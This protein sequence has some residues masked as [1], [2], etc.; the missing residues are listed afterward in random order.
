MKAKG[1]LILAIITILLV[2][3]PLTAAEDAVIAG[4]APEKEWDKTFGGSSGD[5][6]RSVAQTSDGGYIIT[7]TTFSYGAGSSDIWL[8]KT[9]AS[10]NEEWN[11]TFGGESRDDGYCVVQ[12]TDGGYVIAGTSQSYGAGYGDIWI[13]KTDASGNEDWIQLVG[14]TSVDMGYSVIQTAEGGYTAVGTWTAGTPGY[15]I[16]LV[17]ID[18]EGSFLGTVSIGGSDDDYG[19]SIAQRTDGG[20]I[21]VGYT[22]SYGEGSTDVWLVK[23]DAYGNIVWDKTFGG[24]GAEYGNDV[25]QTSD[26]GY[27]IA[28]YTNSFDVWLIKTDASG[29]EEWDKTFGG[30]NSDEGKS[31]AQT[32]DGG[33][34]ITGYTYSYGS[35]YGD[36]WLIKT[37]A[38]GNE[39]WNKT[40]G[41]SNDDGGLS[42]A[43]T[44]DGGYIVT[45]ETGSYGAGFS[46]VW[47]IKVGASTVLAGDAN[48]DGVVNALDITKVERI[49]A[50]LDAQTAG[51]D[52]NQ[53]GAVNALDITKV[54]RIIAGLD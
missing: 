22:Y 46:D 1:K 45:G 49:V 8:V 30:V 5:I 16:L 37:D 38:S 29:N 3:V 4:T 39:E 7:G 17:K 43:V 21:I 54:E 11:K 47:L 23:T 12:T 25:A 40:F 33:Y 13:I 19:S 15:D 27:I 31:V 35:G 34:I 36:V 14:S 44:S 26:G 24:S 48:G 42:V 20:Y 32:A 6:G 50:G 51:A 10:G 18:A 2:I 53:D 52:A 28:G 9:D 41:G